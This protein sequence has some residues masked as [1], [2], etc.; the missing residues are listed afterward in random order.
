MKFTAEINDKYV[1]G[2]A[3]KFYQH[4]PN[5]EPLTTEQ[6]ENIVRS[7]YEEIL[8]NDVSGVISVDPDVQAKEA[9]VSAKQQELEALKAQKLQEAIPTVD[10]QA[11]ALAET[12]L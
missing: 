7:H 8:K 9:E 4:D 12:K 11:A 10:A 6:Q 2:L 1:S 5:K 3:D